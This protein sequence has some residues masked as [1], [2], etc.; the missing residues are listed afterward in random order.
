MARLEDAA[1][2]AIARR[3]ILRH[4]FGRN[5]PLTRVAGTRGGDR[6]IERMWE[7]SHQADNR[8]RGAKGH[9]HSRTIAPERIVSSHTGPVA[10]EMLLHRSWSIGNNWR[11]CSIFGHRSGMP[12]KGKPLNG[13]CS[14]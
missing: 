13:P 7:R 10:W 1:R 8:R 14:E 12:G 11:V 4:L 5:D 9:L 6:I 2:Q 3:G